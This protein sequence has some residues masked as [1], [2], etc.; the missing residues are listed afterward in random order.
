MFS[1]GRKRSDEIVIAN[2]FLHH[3]EDARLA[4]LL[5]NISER[6]KLFIAVEPHRFRFASLCAQMLWLHWLQ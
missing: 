6:A 4:E 1:T 5:R 2:L 3:F